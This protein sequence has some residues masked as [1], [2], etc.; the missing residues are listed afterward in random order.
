MMINNNNSADWTIHILILNYWDPFKRDFEHVH[1][2]V[3][4]DTDSVYVKFYVFCNKPPCN[5]NVI[6]C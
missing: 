2:F 5:F 6:L 3:N 1:M 4:N